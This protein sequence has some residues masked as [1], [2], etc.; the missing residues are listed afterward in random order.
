MEPPKELAGTEPQKKFNKI[1]AFKLT[2]HVKF[3]CET[4][5]RRKRLVETR[6]QPTS[7]AAKIRLCERGRQG[8][9]E[10]SRQKP[11]SRSRAPAAAEVP[12]TRFH[13][14]WKRP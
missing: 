4:E 10:G 5:S 14:E 12:E 7:T 3:K 6:P 2:S 8:Q 11:D 13:R 1:S 9:A